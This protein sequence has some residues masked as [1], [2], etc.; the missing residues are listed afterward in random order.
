[1]RSAPGD[2]ASVPSEDPSDGFCLIVS[3]LVSLLDR[4]RACLEL[5]K[6]AIVQEASGNREFAN[7]VVL[8]DVMPLYANAASAL[9]AC[10]P[11]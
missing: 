10:E 9:C 2:D 4:V 5:V 11:G 1:M 7:V 8:D 3:D 6:T